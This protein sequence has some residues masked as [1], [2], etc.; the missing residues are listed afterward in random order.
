M[1]PGA[2]DRELVEALRRGEEAAFARLG[3]AI[4]AAA[5]VLG[6]RAALAHGRH[7]DAPDA[8]GPRIRPAPT[9]A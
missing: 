9:S 4:L 1:L 5:A 8:A 7:G 2:S 3:A 6:D